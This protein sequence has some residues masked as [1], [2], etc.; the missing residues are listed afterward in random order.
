MQK[1]CI[2]I[3][4]PESWQGLDLGA[5]AD[6]M[7]RRLRRYSQRINACLVLVLLMCTSV[8][9]ID[10]KANVTPRADGDAQLEHCGTEY[11]IR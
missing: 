3:A 7:R 5:V 2:Q 10:R 1:E 11:E 4:T 6:S 8:K 9:T